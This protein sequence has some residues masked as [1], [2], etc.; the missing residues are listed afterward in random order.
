[1]SAALEAARRQSLQI[2]F[3]K[4]GPFSLLGRSIIGYK[5][6]VSKS[7]AEARAR[8]SL[9]LQELS[10]I[11]KGMVLEYQLKATC[12]VVDFSELAASL[13]SIYTYVN[14]PIRRL[15]VINK[16]KH[17]TLYR[18]LTALGTYSQYDP[19]NTPVWKC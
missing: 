17:L 15:R 3:D 9:D 7:S 16:L 4:N 5:E 6:A 18:S 2:V 19:T 1:M 14:F 10:A 11:E 12:S 13:L 8:L